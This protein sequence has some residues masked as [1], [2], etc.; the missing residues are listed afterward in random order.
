MP[1]ASNQSLPAPVRKHFACRS[2]VDLSRGVQPRLVGLRTEYPAGRDR[3]SRG[4]G[5]G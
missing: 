3:P 4:I 5:S 1:Y 2:S